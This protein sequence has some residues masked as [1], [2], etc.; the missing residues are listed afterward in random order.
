MFS[1]TLKKLR[2]P[3]F[4][5][6]GKQTQACG[7]PLHFG[8]EEHGNSP[9]H[10]PSHS[11][12]KPRE[13]KSGLL[14]CTKCRAKYPIL[15]GVAILTAD[16][17][18]Y[19]IEHVKGI[20]AL[21]PDS[22]IPREYREEY[23]EAKSDI[24]IEHI[25]EDLEAERVNSLYFLNHYLRTD[26]EKWWKPTVGA[27]SPL[28]DELVRKYWDHGPFA[29][30]ESRLVK[31]GK[32]YD[33]VELGCGLGGLFNVLKPVC[34]SFLGVDSSF[35]SIAL[36]RHLALGIPYR[37]KLR[38]PEDLLQ[39]AV[40]RA[41]RYES[42]KSSDGKADF[43]VGDLGSV[44]VVSG[45]CDLTIALNA[46]D[47]MPEPWRLPELQF[48]LL[49]KG[50][51][52]VQSCPYIW[53]EQVAESLRNRLPEEIRDSA[54][55]AEWLYEEAGFKISEKVDHVPWLFFKHARQLEIYSVHIFIAQKN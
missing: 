8:E 52:A 16:V 42:A 5:K 36:A 48:E 30:I 44:P 19:L 27:A 15:A 28:I 6:R 10:L 46:I 50:G 43:V 23:R 26:G 29:Q 39:G 45:E 53:H 9:N 54:G 7:A 24:Q 2:C 47:M 40:S 49:R 3:S 18:T 51:I 11:G 13:I 32:S 34:S 31:E 55:A 20:S 1:T 17:R 35:A 37:G 4:P 12:E 14:W 33:I 21:V 25:E 41:V 22:D 38:I